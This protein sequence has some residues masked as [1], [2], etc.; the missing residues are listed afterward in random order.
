MLVIRFTKATR[1]F[2]I[3]AMLLVTALIS[4]STRSI[5]VSAPYAPPGPVQV[6]SFPLPGSSPAAPNLR[7]LTADLDYLAR[8]G[9]S[10]LSEQ[11]L[12]AALRRETPLP[13]EPVLLLFDDAAEGFAQLRPLLEER[14]L[15]WIP[16]EKSAL[17]TQELRAAGYAVTRLERTGGFALEDQLR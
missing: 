9:R 4:I 16:R 15:P 7:T 14:G 5:S 2:C 13:A 3:C 12:V 17:L 1:F 10:V 6:V 11:A 8:S